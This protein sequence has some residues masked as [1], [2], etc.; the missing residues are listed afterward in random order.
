MQQLQDLRPDF[1]HVTGAFDAAGR[2]VFPNARYLVGRAEYEFWWEEP[3][4]TELPVPDEIRQ[5]LREAAKAA[6]VA[7]RGRIDQVAPGDEVASGVSVVDA[8]GHT[9]GHLA[10]EV[11]AD[12]ERLLLV[13]DAA[14]QPVLHLEHPDWFAGSDNWPVQSVVSRRLLLDRAAAEDL[15]VA[16]Y[17]FPFPGLGRVAKE[18]DGWRWQPAA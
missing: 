5:S 9:P 2:P 8:A 17:H 18:G 14:S 11:A 12:G 15:L 7:L 10:I 3:S 6:L 4:L 13:G 1:D 16:T